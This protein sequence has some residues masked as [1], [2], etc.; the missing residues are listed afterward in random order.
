MGVVS[1]RPR[2]TAWWSAPFRK[3][4]TS[5]RLRSESYTGLSDES[6]I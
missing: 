6:G 4:Q 1:R 3:M 5:R 2:T